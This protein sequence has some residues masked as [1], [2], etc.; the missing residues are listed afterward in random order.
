[1]V[2]VCGCRRSQCICVRG[3]LGAI[4]GMFDQAKSVGVARVN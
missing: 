2:G 3:C 4:M 1:M